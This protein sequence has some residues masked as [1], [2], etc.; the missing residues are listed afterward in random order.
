MGKYKVSFKKHGATSADHI[1]YAII[2]EANTLGE[3]QTRALREITSLHQKGF[4]G[5][6]DIIKI[7]QTT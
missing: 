3:A 2:V 7:E 4:L 5:E 1:E 6:Q